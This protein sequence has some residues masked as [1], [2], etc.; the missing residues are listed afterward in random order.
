MDEIKVICYFCG[1]MSCFAGLIMYGREVKTDG[2]ILTGGILIV[3]GVILLLFSYTNDQGG[4]DMAFMVVVKK[5]EGPDAFLVP[6]TGEEHLTKQEALTVYLEAAEDPE[7][8]DPY[9]VIV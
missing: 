6:Y 4:F 1:V 8:G 5:L 2:S 7:V 3:V 9:I